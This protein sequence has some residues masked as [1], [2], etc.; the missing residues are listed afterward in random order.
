MTKNSPHQSI[1]RLYISYFTSFHCRS[2]ARWCG[3]FQDV[4]ASPWGRPTS[5]GPDLERESDPQPQAPSPRRQRLPTAKLLHI[6]ALW[7]DHWQNYN[8]ENNYNNQNNSNNLNIF[9]IITNNWFH[10]TK[11]NYYQIITNNQYQTIIN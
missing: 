4:S 6:F 7:R 3:F 1:F 2:C 10:I 5:P 8:N 9:Q 11:N